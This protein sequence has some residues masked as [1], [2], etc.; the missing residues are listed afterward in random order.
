[1]TNNL[2]SV[3][4]FLGQYYTEVY[5]S[6]KQEKYK[7]SGLESLFEQ[8]F[9]IPNEQHNVTVSNTLYGHVIEITGNKVV[10]SK[11][12]YEN[13]HITVATAANSEVNPR[14]LYTPNVFSTLAYLVTNN[15]LLVS[16]TG[17]IDDPIYIK[18]GSHFETFQNTVVVVNIAEDI[19]VDIVEE[20]ASVSA[21][22]GVINYIIGQES[23]LSLYTFYKNSISSVSA[24]C[25]HVISRFSSTYNHVVLGKGSAIALDENKLYTYNDS[26]I[27]LLGCVDS[28][29]YRFNSILSYHPESKDYSIVVDYRAITYDKGLVEFYPLIYGQNPNDNA[30]I[31]ITEFSI[32]EI[33]E[34]MQTSRHSYLKDIMDYTNIGVLTPSVKRFYENK[35]NFLKFTR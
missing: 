5:E 25:R 21:I 6:S 8:R 31:S 26:Q 3:K 4:S 12:L 17:P 10:V 15:H 19:E 33:L 35:T 9:I 16:I 13:E 32:D 11:A 28:K 14:V 2:V 1:M 22:N 29:K 18:I 30:T 27:M 34:D 7:N 24:L 20:V 23:V